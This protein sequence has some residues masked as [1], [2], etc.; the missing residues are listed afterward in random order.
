MQR[1]ERYVDGLVFGYQTHRISNCNLRGARYY[2][3]VLGPVMVALQAQCRT[4]MHGYPF[5][6]ETIRKHERLEP[7][8]W[9]VIFRELGRLFGAF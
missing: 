1:A 9:P 3:P 6:L 8:P 2:D 7:A 4:R 5:H